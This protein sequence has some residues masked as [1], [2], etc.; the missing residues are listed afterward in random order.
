MYSWMK[1]LF[2]VS[3]LSLGSRGIFV[4]EE[5]SRTVVIKQCKNFEVYLQYIQTLKN[6]TSYISS[7][8]LIHIHFRVRLKY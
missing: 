3:E 6:M 8:I 7:T 2:P 4:S 1:K 5:R